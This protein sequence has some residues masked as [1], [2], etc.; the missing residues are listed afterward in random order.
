MAK[1]KKQKKIKRELEKFQRTGRYWDWL[2]TMENEPASPDL[3]K[4]KE[5]VCRD[6]AGRAVRSPEAFQEFC[7]ETEALSE[8]PSFPDMNFLLALRDFMG[9]AGTEG[10]F[11]AVGGL[12]PPV[13][14]LYE[15]ARSLSDDKGPSRKILTLLER[16]VKQ[17]EKISRRHYQDLARLLNG[18][19][20]AAPVK[21][22]GEEIGHFRK[23]NH[24]AVLTGPLEKVRS[25][26]LG[27]AD[28]SLA[29]IFRRLPE[30]L[31]Q[32]LRFP[33]CM[34]AALFLKNC[35]QRPQARWLAAFLNRLEYLAP[36][37][38]G[39][40]A[41]QVLQD[42]ALEH[43]SA[44]ELHDTFAIK[45]SFVS[46]EIEEK[47]Q[48][49]TRIRKSIYLT[50]HQECDGFRTPDDE[51]S[52]QI[53]SLAELLAYC[54]NHILT[55]L[56]TLKSDL[57]KRDQK[58]LV[59]I[60]DPMIAQDL[61]IIED[62]DGGGF[63]YLLIARAAAA[64][65]MGKRLALLG[66]VTDRKSGTGRLRSVVERIFND[67]PLPD[68]QDLDWITKQWGDYLCLSSRAMA[69]ILIKLQPDR[70]LTEHF[71]YRVWGHFVAACSVLGSID[72]PFSNMIM[73][74]DLHEDVQEAFL[75]KKREIRLLYKDFPQLNIIREFLT[76]FP[77]GRLD[78]EG[79]QKWYEITWSDPSL[80]MYFD[81][82]IIVTA[83]PLM[84]GM[85][86]GLDSLLDLLIADS[87]PKQ[88]PMGEQL[89]QF[90]KDH[91]EDFRKMP[92]D[93]LEE[94][95]NIIFDLFEGVRHDGTL[96]I[97][98][99]NIISIRVDSGE[100]GLEWIRDELMRH[101]KTRI[102]SRGKTGKKR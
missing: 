32:V 102:Q 7:R 47:F 40:K 5:R 55:E 96:A 82:M 88:H 33:F 64:G 46:A 62:E 86:D 4:E 57:S 20:I 11:S 38:V 71:V 9:G 91:D 89:L 34:Q 24:K 52:E 18:L 59:R 35:G 81:D 94:V 92:Q 76:L 60:M 84:G 14:A 27:K 70:E 83:S 23:L 13:Q 69:T 12:S 67:L 48:I 93:R 66:I 30:P 36:H 68:K 65:C 98:L 8:I 49:L 39:E 61:D 53:G 22:L 6:L 1:K 58:N 78:R 51:D 16:F 54:Y 21:A 75:H 90:F 87:R 73:G 97:R 15:K 95:M 101:L 17:P 31:G 99:F 25:I 45:E 28:R 44:L 74:R 2:K 63:P 43:P 50:L 26:D 77:N 41:D 72:N 19:D 29:S 80:S 10:S 79:L 3:Q 37:I 85:S 100:K 42:L 56:V